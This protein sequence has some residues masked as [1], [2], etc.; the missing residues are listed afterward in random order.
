MRLLIAALVTQFVLARFCGASFA[1]ATTVY[2]VRHAEKQTGGT[3]P[4]L[5][6]AGRLRAQQLALVL[7]SANLKACIASQFLRTQQTAKPA[8]KLAKLKVLQRPAGKEQQLAYEMR[9]DFKGQSVLFVGHSNTVPQLLK[10]LGAKHVPAIG[11]SD[12]DNLF[13]VQISDSGQ[14]SVLQLHYGSMTSKT[15]DPKSTVD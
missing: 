14:T 3:D 12:Y 10:H 13:V 4:S 6:A 7:R 15:S 8:A 2:L 5:D 1:D 11:E 9:Q